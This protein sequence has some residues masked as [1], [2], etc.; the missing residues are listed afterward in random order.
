MSFWI[1]KPRV[2]F[3]LFWFA[4]LISFACYIVFLMPTASVNLASSE[5]EMSKIEK[6]FF[7]V[8]LAILFLVSLLRW[9]VFPIVKNILLRFKLYIALLSAGQA[10]SFFAFF[11]VRAEHKSLMLGMI[12]VSGICLLQMMPLFCLKKVDDI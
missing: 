10:V 7:G 11:L 3:W 9:L 1:E 12:F 8:S 6:I 4:F 2:F 5:V